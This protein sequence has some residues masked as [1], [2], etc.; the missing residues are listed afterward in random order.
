MQILRKNTGL[1]AILAMATLVVMSASASAQV[2]DTT[3]T[4]S[5]DVQPALSI[6]RVTSPS[7]GKVVK[8]AAGTARYKLDYATGAVTLV[9]GNGYAF[10][11]GQ[12][13]EYTVTGAPNAPI[14]FQVDIDTFS[15]TGVSVV[16]AHINGTAATGTGTIAG[17]GTYTLKIGGTI[18]VASTA[19][20]EVQTATVTVT[21]DYQ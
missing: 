16:L 6:A 1:K 17:G 4:A 14:S 20:V 12:L 7:W 8:P 15:G 2:I 9:S 11:D 5:V 13:G 3:G 18:D 19:S 21:V 10:D